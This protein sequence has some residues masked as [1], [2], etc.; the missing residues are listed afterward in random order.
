MRLCLLASGSKGN[1]AILEVNR[2]RI[3]IDAGISARDLAR[4]LELV[5]IDGQD[6]DALVITHEHT[7]HVRGLGPLVRRY[8]LPVYLHTEI[9]GQLADIG[10]TA[11]VRE[12]APGQAW[13]IGDVEVRAF[14]V[15]HDA[16]SPVGFTFSCEA[17][18]IGM[19]TDLGA[20]TRLV[21]QQLMGCRALI[22]ETN[23]DESM[24][25]DGPYPWPLKQRV[26]SR[27]G[28]LSNPAAA[29]LLDSLLWDGL[30]ALVLAHLS[31]T[32]N[33]PVLARQAVDRVLSAQTL[34][35]PRVTVGSQ[36]V[37]TAWVELD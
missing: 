4:R 3:L 34:C 23:H 20:A 35:A 7:D 18:K 25:R 16:I 13:S 30:E 21:E 24:L 2:T 19:A 32:N 36:S 26:R 27:H 37:P 14:S 6:L 1:A 22:L 31:A 15:T 8:N 12:F 10:R 5:G 28:H 29:E 17:G 33:L 11:A 9:A